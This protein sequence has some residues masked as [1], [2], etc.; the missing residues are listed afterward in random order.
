MAIGEKLKEERVRL[1]YSLEEVEEET[2]IRKYYLEAIENENFAVLPP[3]VYAVGFVKRYAKFLG[4]D[5]QE[6]ANEFKQTA[7][8]NDIELNENFDIDKI[9]KTSHVPNME[10]NIS[11]KNVLIALAFLAVVIWAGDYLITYFTKEHNI[12]PNQGNQQIVQ[13][14]QGEE[15]NNIEENI[16]DEELPSGVEIVIEASQNCW[17]NVVVDDVS[18]YNAILPAGETLTFNGTNKIY[19]KAGN[20]GGIKIIYNGMEMPTLGEI[21]E[22]KEA[23]YTP[24]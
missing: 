20:A 12:P 2:K 15:D 3:K 24:F 16:I 5:E 23:I 11:L 18:Q 10:S 14:N 13:P 19:L 21:G 8:P 22:V 7:Y 9:E 4:L 6:F 1:G 17:L